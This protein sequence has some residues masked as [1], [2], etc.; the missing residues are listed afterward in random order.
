MKW[1]NEESPRGDYDSADYLTASIPADEDEM[2]GIQNGGA[3]NQKSAITIKDSAA[4]S[5]A[6]KKNE[7]NTSKPRI[8]P[9]ARNIINMVQKNENNPFKPANSGCN[10]RVNSVSN[11][12]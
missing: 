9:T 3:G 7:K 6:D 2:R 10:S 8:G 5:L 4:L 12:A 1:Q 11:S